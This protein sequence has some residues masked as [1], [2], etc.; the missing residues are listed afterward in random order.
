[1]SNVKALIPL[2]LYRIGGLPDD[3]AKETA[4]RLLARALNEIPAPLGDGEDEGSGAPEPPHIVAA[5]FERALAMARA[6]S[7]PAARIR[8]FGDACEA[9]AVSL[10]PLSGRRALL[11][12][13]LDVA[14]V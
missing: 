7:N 9:I 6:F 13:A 12:H 1:M 5:A 14:L 2:A 11:D 10:L 3:E 8:A 4:L